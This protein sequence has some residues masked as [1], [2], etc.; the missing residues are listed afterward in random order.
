MAQQFASFEV[1]AGGHH[2]QPVVECKQFD[3]YWTFNVTPC[4]FVVQVTVFVTYGDPSEILFRMEYNNS[5][6]KLFKDEKSYKVPGLIHPNHLKIEGYRTKTI[7]LSRP[8]ADE[9]TFFI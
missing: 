3:Q 1:P 2:V 6:V 4:R 5:G 8:P 9:D 7:T